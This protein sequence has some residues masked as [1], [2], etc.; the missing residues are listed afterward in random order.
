MIYGIH[1]P[2]KMNPK[3]LVDHLT[4]SSY[5]SFTF[6]SQFTATTNGQINVTLTCSH[7]SSVQFVFLF[8][9]DIFIIREYFTLVAQ[10]VEQ[11]SFYCRVGGSVPHSSCHMLKCPWARH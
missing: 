2:Q 5:K 4:S 6:Q 3:N 7:F 8:C 9:D 1:G 10:E 11:S